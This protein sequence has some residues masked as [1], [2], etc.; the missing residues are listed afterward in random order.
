MYS[1]WPKHVLKRDDFIESNLTGDQPEAINFIDEFLN[2]DKKEAAITGFPGVGK[3]YIIKVIMQEYGGKAVLLAPTHKAKYVL[4]SATGFSAQTIHKANGLKPQM[5]LSEF[6]VNNLILSSN[7]SVGLINN[8]LILADE[9][10]MYNGAY[11]ELNRYNSKDKAKILYFGDKYQLPPVEKGSSGYGQVI[12]SPM[13]DL[14]DI[15]HMSKVVRQR[16]GVSILD[17]ASALRYDID[18]D[19]ATA[20]ELIAKIP[21][22]LKD[23]EGYNVENLK[24]SLSRAADMTIKY[25]QKNEYQ[26]YRIFTFSREM[27]QVINRAIRQLV[28]KPKF[29]VE[30]GDFLTS[31][32]TI[33]N[34][35]MDPT[36]INSV[37]Y[38]VTN[39]RMYKDSN[40]MKCFVTTI[41]NLDNAKD[42]QDAVFVDHNDPESIRIYL[43]IYNKLR[44]DA[45]N[46]PPGGFKKHKWEV[47]YNFV[48]NHLTLVP[49]TNDM[50]PDFTYGYSNTTHKAQ[51]I[52]CKESCIILDDILSSPN[53]QF[54]LRLWHVAATRAKHRLDIAY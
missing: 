28:L 11:M 37:D 40:G 7:G 45:I 20:S 22:N 25:Q 29:A 33:Y 32:V 53:R 8:D 34:E 2:S 23:G 21:H 5:D 24:K 18:N 1:I 50:Q 14:P 13:F 51:G 6:D 35:N 12:M 43:G 54:A 3:T 38:L 19:S 30:E 46:T 10:S 44:I 48:H 27:S 52:T 47:F 4:E 41:L 36:I 16:E 39:C 42:T 49:F 31:Q 17:L 9:G 15:F 26:S